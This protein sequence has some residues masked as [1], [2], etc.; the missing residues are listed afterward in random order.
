MVGS[1]PASS[2][3]DSLNEELDD[4][5]ESNGKAW[6]ARILFRA[7][8]QKG[9]NYVDLRKRINLVSACAGCFAEAA[10]LK[11]RFCRECIQLNN[12]LL[13]QLQASSCYS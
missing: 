11:D 10:V 12:G 1:R 4:L 13:H 8:Q 3:S 6:W 2:V 9:Y 5:D 7:A